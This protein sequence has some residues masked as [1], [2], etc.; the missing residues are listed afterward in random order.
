MNANGALSTPN[1]IQLAAD[2]PGIAAF[3]SGGI[4]AEHSADASL[5]TEAAPAAPG[6]YVVFYVSGM[7]LTDNPVASGQPSPGNP[8]ARPTDPPTLTLNGNE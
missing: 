3:A 2:A 8:L 1:P 6:E 4:I 5:V 7:G